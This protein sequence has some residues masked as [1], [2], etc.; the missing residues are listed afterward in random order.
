LSARGI[1]RTYQELSGEGATNVKEIAVRALQGDASAL[2]AFTV[3]GGRLGRFLSPWLS[4]FRADCLVI[5]GSI[6][7][8]HTLFL[9]ALQQELGK[10]HIQVSIKI[11]EKTE[12]S[13]I[14]GAAVL[15]GR[16]NKKNGEQTSSWRLSS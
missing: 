10:E 8:S 3:F 13:S 6:A 12:L 4:R 2:S 5:G 14:A 1:L 7:R 11:S 9:P 16:Q 15:A